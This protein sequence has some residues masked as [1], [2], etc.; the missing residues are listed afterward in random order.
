MFDPTIFDN[1]K[2][3]IEGAVY[4]LD[5]AGAIFV[6]DR[7]DQVDLA[8]M[9]RKYQ[10][11]FRE[12][13]AKTNSLA[14]IQLRI[15]ST[16]LFDEINERAD[17]YIGCQLMIAFETDAINVDDDCPKLDALMKE[18]WANR[19]KVEQKLSFIFGAWPPKCANRITLD[20]GRKINEEQIEDIESLVDHVLHTLQRINQMKLNQRSDH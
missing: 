8:K 3:V 19:P 7:A 20:F 12:Q 13:G 6:T 2:V 15:D 18:I 14:E 1:L 10:I 5:A 17:R 11:Q 9:T 16:D 4:D